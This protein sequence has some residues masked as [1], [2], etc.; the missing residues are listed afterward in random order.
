[1]QRHELFCFALVMSGS[2]G[3]KN[4]MRKKEEN[5]KRREEMREGKED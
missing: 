2:T 4:V 3:S 5:K 1:M